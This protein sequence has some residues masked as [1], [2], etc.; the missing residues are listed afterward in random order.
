MVVRVLVNDGRDQER[1]EE[2]AGHILPDAYP[3]AARKSRH[4]RSIGRVGI[5]PHGDSRVAEDGDDVKGVDDIAH[6]QP[7]LFAGCER[8]DLRPI[9]EAGVPVCH[10]RRAAHHFDRR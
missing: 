3:H 1:V 2:F 4:A 6:R 5:G 8:L 10:R 9:G 7:T